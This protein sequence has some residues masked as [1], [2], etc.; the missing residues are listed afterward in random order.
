MD[1]MKNLNQR[2]TVEEGKVCYGGEEKIKEV[3][4][5]SPIQLPSDYVDFLACISGEDN[6]GI[7]FS[8]DGSGNE[9]FIWSAEMALMK[10]EEFDLPIPNHKEFM[11]S[12]WLLGDDV[13][14]LVFFYG[15]GNNGFG[16]YRASAGGIGFKHA[17]K[18]ANTLTEFLVDG[19]GID[20]AITL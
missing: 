20:I 2:L 8:V 1:I 11:E 17:E 13:G 4:E 14:D 18:I 10:Y 19:I 7:A 15:E 12:V 16:I 6:I 5:K 9:I 3:L